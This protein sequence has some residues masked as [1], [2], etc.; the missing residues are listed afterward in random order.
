MIKLLDSTLVVNEVVEE[1]LKLFFLSRIRL[2]TNNPKKMKA[3]KQINVVERYPSITPT[4]T[5]NENYLRVKKTLM[6]HLL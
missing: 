4:N 5:H 1:I 2:I 3:F 6:G